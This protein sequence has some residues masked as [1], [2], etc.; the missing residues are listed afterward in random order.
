[1]AKQKSVIPM[2]GTIGGIN[3]YFLHGKPVA[4]IAGGGF[5]SKDV[6]TK[7]SMQRVRE[8]GSEFGDCS[9]VN[10]KFRE[11]L[12]P[13]YS[14]HKFTFF[15]SRLMTLF[16]AIKALD[17]V[18]ARGKRQVFRGLEHDAGKALL[19]D[20]K[21][22]PDCVLS[23]VLPFESTMDWATYTFQ[24]PK[25]S[26]DRVSFI[27]GA[28]HV[29]LQF[30]VLDFNFETLEYALHMA[31]GQMLPKDFAG[32]RLSM[33]STSLPTGLG[34]QLAVLGI[35]YYQEVDGAMYLLHAQ[36]GVGIAVV[37]IK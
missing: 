12:R 16:T 35:R 22:T 17:V 1:M 37:S 36:N 14:H 20:F 27:A 2:V 15:H 13:F 10:K 18:S 3:F 30:G 25:F 19:R 31:D 9:R 24:F 5:N 8:N 29:A 28:T 23:Q 21:Y 4:R 33:T 6:R 26:M 32:T 11:A 34:I 7:K